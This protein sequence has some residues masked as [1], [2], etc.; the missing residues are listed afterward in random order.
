VATKEETAMEVELDQLIEKIKREG[1]DEAQQASQAVMGKA[2]EE[3]RT[4]VENARREAETIVDTARLRAAK[5]EENGVLALR[6]AARDIVLLLQARIEAL[7]DRVFRKRVASALT[8]ETLKEL[9][10]TVVAAWAGG[11]RVEVGL[12][13]T[14]K[15]QLQGLLFAGLREELKDSI[16]LVVNRKVARG[17]RLGIQGEDVHYDFTDETIA[18]VLKSYVGADLRRLLDETNG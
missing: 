17:F 5:L 13:E 9:I 2:M 14:D 10:S 7:F 1:L 15:E 3:A 11:A 16:T 8:P 6:Q 12:S 4:I 18:A